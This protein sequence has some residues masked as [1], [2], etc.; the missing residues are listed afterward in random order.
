MCKDTYKRTRNIKLA[1]IFFIVSTNIFE[2]HL[3]DN[4]KRTRNM[5]FVSIFSPQTPKDDKK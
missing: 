3:S 2:V 4:N 5:K 1:R